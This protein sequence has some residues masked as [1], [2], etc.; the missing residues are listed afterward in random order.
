MDKWYVY[1]LLNAGHVAY[2]GIAKD[3]QTRLDQHNNGKGARFTRGRG[4]WRIIHT[5]GPLDHPQALKR[6]IALKKDAAFKRRLKAAE[7]G[8]G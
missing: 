7:R 5:E 3:V 6:E 8:K 2:T 1:I 4:P